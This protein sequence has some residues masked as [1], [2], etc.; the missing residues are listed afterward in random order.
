MFIN[1]IFNKIYIFTTNIQTIIE[2]PTSDSGINT[3]S[4]LTNENL[5]PSPTL[6]HLTQG[7][8]RHLQNVL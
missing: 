6:H 4:A 2:T 1:W 7:N 8:I 5:L 3:I